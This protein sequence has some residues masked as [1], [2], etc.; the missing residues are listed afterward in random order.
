MAANR[1]KKTHKLN[2]DSGHTSYIFSHSCNLLAKCKILG[3]FGHLHTYI[4]SIF[5]LMFM[6][7]SIICF[8]Q[9]LGN[10]LYYPQSSKRHV[11]VIEPRSRGT[12]H[13][14]PCATPGGMAWS[15]GSLEIAMVACLGSNKE[16]QNR[17]HLCHPKISYKATLLSTGES[18]PIS[19][20]F[21]VVTSFQSPQSRSKLA[22]S[23]STR[24]HRCI[25]CIFFT[26]HGIWGSGAKCLEATGECLAVVSAYLFGF[27][28]H[29]L[30]YVQNLSVVYW[31][32]AYLSVF[33]SKGVLSSVLVVNFQL[34]L[35]WT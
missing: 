4:E 33:F 16:K 20:I 13:S 31:H 9:L 25:Q 14:E 12:S 21:C 18:W 11:D 19:W 30:V 6:L 29:N 24:S 2:S 8:T 22:P 5:W 15:V 32:F 1:R 10:F 3:R 35:T 34:Q 27:L 28:L 7:H 26:N 17:W 23:H